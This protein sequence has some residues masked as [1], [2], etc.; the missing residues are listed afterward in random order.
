MYHLIKPQRTEK[1]NAPLHTWLHFNKKLK[2]R[3][4]LV[5]NCQVISWNILITE[6]IWQP[7]LMSSPCDEKNTNL[8]AFC[9][10]WH[11]I[12][13]T[14]NPFCL[15]CFPPPHLLFPSATHLSSACWGNE[16]TLGET[17][18]VCPCS[19]HGEL[20]LTLALGD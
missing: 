17:H 6:P 9:Q 8:R 18:A 13:T 14:A 3:V 19:K 12:K 1:Q 7:P 2:S 20:L 16:S 5:S 11:Q 15:A 10:T 4:R